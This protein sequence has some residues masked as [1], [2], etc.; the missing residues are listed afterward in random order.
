MKIVFRLIVVVIAI[1]LAVFAVSNRSAVELGLWPLPGALSLPLYLLV[2]AA[3]LVGFVVGQLT[4]W[5]AGRHW[6]REAREANRRIA[7]L[8]GELDD[9]RAEARVTHEAA[10]QSPVATGETLP[11]SRR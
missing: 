5:I 1:V 3:L 7:A 9:A 2:L 11:I 6:R 10:P 4:A 8:E